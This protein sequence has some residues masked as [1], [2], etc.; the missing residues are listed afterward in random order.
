ML[1]LGAALAGVIRVYRTSRWYVPPHQALCVVG[2]SGFLYL[3]LI[4][5]GRGWSDNERNAARH[6]AWQVYLCLR[7]GY[8][9]ATTL[10]NA[11]EAGSPTP[12]DS[13]RDAANNGAAR[14]WFRVHEDEIRRDVGRLVGPIDLSR[15]VGH[16]RRLYREGGM[17]AR[18]TAERPRKG[19]HG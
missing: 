2:A 15:L 16:G 19:F 5:R 17:F 8:A 4:W 13:V 12:A 9:G 18:G 6:L 3:L 14:D 1:S 11:H 7:L 10:G